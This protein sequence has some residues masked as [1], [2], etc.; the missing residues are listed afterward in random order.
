MQTVGSSLK[1]QE[2]SGEEWVDK[3]ESLAV[4]ISYGKH[5]L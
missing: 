5:T 4:Y 3:V 2:K 1:K